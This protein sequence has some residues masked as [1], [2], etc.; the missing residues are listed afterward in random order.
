MTV[1]TPIYNY[2]PPLKLSRPVRRYT[3]EQYVEKEA[4]TKQKHDFIDGQFIP[5]PYAK[6]PHNIISANI[7]TEMSLSF[8][9][10]EEKYV[11][12]SSDQKIYFPSLGDG[13][14]ADALAVCKEPQYWDDNSLL[15]INPMIVVEVLSK[16]TSRYDRNGKFDKYKTL[17]SF[18]EY[19]L[20]RQDEYYAEVWY[21]ESPGRWQETIITDISQSIELQSVE[22]SLS[23]EWIYHNV[24]LKK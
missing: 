24:D 19:I 1:K 15:L 3:L 6:G 17:E 20:I 8:R 11:V 2:E 9:K 13:V 7:M 14:Y 22:I 21:R 12:F 16:S 10:L 5:M 18:K 23:M 4:K